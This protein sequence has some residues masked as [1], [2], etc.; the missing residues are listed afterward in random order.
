LVPTLE[1][2]L[3]EFTDSTARI[4]DSFSRYAIAGDTIVLL[5]GTSRGMGIRFLAKRDSLVEKDLDIV[6]Y[7]VR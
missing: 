6:L 3:L 7:R 5:F 1:D 4:G 2:W